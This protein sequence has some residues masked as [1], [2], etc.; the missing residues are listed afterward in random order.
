MCGA[1]WDA[2]VMEDK[3]KKGDLSCTGLDMETLTV[4]ELRGLITE[5]WVKT[6]KHMFRVYKKAVPEVTGD[7]ISW[8]ATHPTILSMRQKVTVKFL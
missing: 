5:E 6:R 1:C 3:L 2:D 7:S 8:L 4:A